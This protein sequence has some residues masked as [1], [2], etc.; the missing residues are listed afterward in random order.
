[1]S[2]L[3][4]FRLSPASLEPVVAARLTAPPLIACLNF[5]AS[6][7]GNIPDNAKS[8]A[9]SRRVGSFNWDWEHGRFSHEWAS[10]AK[11]ETWRRVEE[12]ASSVELVASTTW[13]DRKLYIRLQ[14]FVCG[15]QD[16][17]GGRTYQKK[18]P[19]RERKIPSKKTGCHCEI[20]I[21]QYLHTS[22]VLGRYIAD[23]DHEIGAANIAHTRL[24][25]TTWERI[26]MM[27]VQTIDR[28]EI[29][30]CQSQNSLARLFNTF[31]GTRDS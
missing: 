16:S 10:L 31:E 20:L 12:R 18:N 2:I 24:S 27:L 15:C 29:V 6:S 28:Q 22:T 9:T 8:P 11:F 17:G 26:K 13:P 14:L 7:C 30:S 3:P 4:R 21:K 19:D 1:M 23:H 25:G 5:S